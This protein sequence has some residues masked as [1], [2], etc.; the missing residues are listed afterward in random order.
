MIGFEKYLI[1]LRSNF[2]A[3]FYFNNSNNIPIMDMSN[4]Y[5]FLLNSKLD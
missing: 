4:L 5:L 1:S 2:N 3:T